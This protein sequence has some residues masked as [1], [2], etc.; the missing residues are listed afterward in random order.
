MQRLFDLITPNPK[1][2]WVVFAPLDFHPGD[3]ASRHL[4]DAAKD[5]I[6]INADHA[7]E[8]SPL[9]LLMK[10]QNARGLFTL[11]L[12]RRD[13]PFVPA[14][15]PIVTW[16]LKGP[17]PNAG[18]EAD[19]L[20]VTTEQLRKQAKEMGW[21]RV[22]LGSPQTSSHPSIGSQIRVFGESRWKKSDE[23]EFVHSSHR[24]L[25]EAIGQELADHPF[26][27]TEDVGQFLA[28]RAKKLDIRPT[29]LDARVFID[30][31]IFPA[32]THGILKFLK[33]RG[34]E[35]RSCHA[36]SWEQW[37]AMMRD[38]KVVIN[39][40]PFDAMAA[41]EYS[42]RS[43]VNPL[44]LD[45]NELLQQISSQPRANLQPAPILNFSTL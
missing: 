27:L 25:H 12:S 20:V 8:S 9:G 4:A 22:E 11:R 26:N 34:I 39:T 35:A 19:T 37:D 42:G 6:D 33:S 24:L 16:I 43:V 7:G 40:R 23:R 38:A 45:G 44:G 5:Q 32:Y 29:D 1:G 41:L 30:E 36:S 31:L 2:K 17:I 21:N 18:N 28:A 10:L 3:Y 13:L 14:R 15:V